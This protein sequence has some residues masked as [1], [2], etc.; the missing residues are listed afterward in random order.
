MHVL[1]V[2]KNVIKWYLKSIHVSTPNVGAVLRFWNLLSVWQPPSTVG[3][4]QHR[5]VAT[6]LVTFLLSGRGASG[7][8]E[9]NEGGPGQLTTWIDMHHAELLC[10]APNYKLQ[11]RQ[12]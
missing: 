11:T 6:G 7:P 12:P 10:F 5:S 3:V 8:R 1:L 2:F 9:G 4:L